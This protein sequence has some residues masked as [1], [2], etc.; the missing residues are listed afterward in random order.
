MNHQG[1]IR[2]FDSQLSLIQRFIDALIIIVTLMLSVWLY[3]RQ[4]P[5]NDT[6][7]ITAVSAVVLFYLSAKLNNLYQSYRIGG[8]I[9]EIKPLILSWIGALIGLLVLG[10]SF[11]VTHELS[12][13][14]LGI[15]ALLTPTILT[16]WRGFF[17]RI[18]DITRSKG[19]NSRSVAIVGTGE[20][21][22]SL[23]KNIISMPW[24][25]LVLKGFISQE[26]SSEVCSDEGESWPVLG[27][28]DDLY[29]MARHNQVD[30][31]YLAIP[32]HEQS[33]INVILKEL[34]DSTVSI[35]IVPD[36][37]TAEIMQGDW[38]TVG[39]TPT[40]SVIESPTQGIDSWAKRIEDVVLALLA[41]IIF[42]IPMLLISLGVKLSSPGPVLYKQNR[43]GING[44]PI[45]VWKFRSMS[46]TENDSEF[47]QVK[48]DDARVTKFGRFLRHTSLDEL[49][50]LF[51]VLVGDMSI[52]GPRPHAVAQNEEFRGKVYGYMLRYKVKPGITGLAQ[53]NGF[54]GETDTNEKMEHRVHY[55]VEYI[56]NWSIWLDLVIILKTPWELI[57]GR[58]AY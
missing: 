50:Q 14:S 34:G 11:K 8:I 57:K 12:R 9:H 47:V 44:K 18:L 41:L 20:N 45:R 32:M 6:Y 5:W 10:Y 16:A 17:R 29:D 23:A 51:N 43:Y 48:K 42:S 52:V 49:P 40:V 27:G 19:H 58:N 24:M 31:V 39:D 30:I 56:N 35:F 25:G 15:W 26:P 21:A 7:T 38:V 1:I 54:R 22:K 28:M 2:P 46:V 36:F 4:L 13:V 3:H 55:D 37:Y 53:V 33:I